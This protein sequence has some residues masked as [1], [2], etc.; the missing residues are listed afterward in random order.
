MVNRII[1]SINAEW[2]THHKHCI[3]TVVSTIEIDYK[4][5]RLIFSTTICLHRFSTKEKTC[6]FFSSLSFTNFD[7]RGTYFWFMVCVMIPDT[8]CWH[9]ETDLLSTFFTS[10][11][12]SI[13]L[14]AFDGS[15]NL[16]RVPFLVDDSKISFPW[17]TSE[18]YKNELRCT[19]Q[20]WFTVN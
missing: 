18:V 13:L 4:I 12:L 3:A 7:S 14:F 20:A 9:Y 6:S 2:I 8:G 19:P 15:Y 1:L 5:E 10:F 11:V 17:A 16:D